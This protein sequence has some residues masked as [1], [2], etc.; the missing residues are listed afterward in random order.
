MEDIWMGE[1]GDYIVECIWVG[2]RIYWIGI[3]VVI[4]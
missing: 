3:F 1:N 2:E 4:I